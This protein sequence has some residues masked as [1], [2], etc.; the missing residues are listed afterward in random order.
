MIIALDYDKT[1]TADKY[2]WAIF[3][4]A[5]RKLGH[6]VIC[7]TMRYPKEAIEDMGDIKI[8][9][10]ER[11][12]KLVWAKTNNIDVDIWIDDRPAWLFDD[13]I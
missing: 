4:S 13:A 11:K 12:A 3:I 10:T 9:Y 5:A 8:Y 2:L 6:E 1:Y 7:L